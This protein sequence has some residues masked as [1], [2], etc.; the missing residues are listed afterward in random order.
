VARRKG[1]ALPQIRMGLIHF[2]SLGRPGPFTTKTIRHHRTSQTGGKAHK[3]TR[4]AWGRR[5]CHFDMLKTI[6]PLAT[7]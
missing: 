6:D 1:D 4:T 3:G 2:F 7:G 5:I